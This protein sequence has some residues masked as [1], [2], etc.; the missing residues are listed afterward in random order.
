MEG[1]ENHP[2]GRKRLAL[3]RLFVREFRNVFS[4]F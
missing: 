1:R 4:G 2:A 3:H